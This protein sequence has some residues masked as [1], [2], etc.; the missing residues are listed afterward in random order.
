MAGWCPAAAAHLSRFGAAVS[1]ASVTD[2]Q[3]EYT[4]TF[5]FDPACALELGW[6]LF[7]ESCERGEFLASMRADLARVGVAET[8]G[9]PDHLAHVLTLLGREDRDR[10]RTLASIVERPLGSV[11]AALA[12]RGSRYA[13][14]LTAIEH[15]VALC[16]TGVA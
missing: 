16:R 5:D 10:R 15:A 3:E 13:D 11:A 1:S 7:G 14:L 9:L 4:A 8:Q 2:L 6:H 12:A